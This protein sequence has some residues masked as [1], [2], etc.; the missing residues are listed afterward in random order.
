MPRRDCKCKKKPNAGKEVL[1]QVGTFERVEWLKKRVSKSRLTDRTVKL[2]YLVHPAEMNEHIAAK[3]VFKRFD[4]D[5][6]S[7]LK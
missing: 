2:K 6:N 1:T 7:K 5:G 4:E 3:K